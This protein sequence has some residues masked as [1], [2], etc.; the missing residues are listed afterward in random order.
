MSVNKTVENVYIRQS[1][2]HIA[3]QHFWRLLIINVIYIVFVSGLQELLSSIISA[4]M[5]PDILSAAQQ[6][7]ALSSQA[8]YEAVAGLLL[9]PK[10]LLLFFLS[11]LIEGLVISGLSLGMSHQFLAAAK[12]E[13]PSPLGLF[14]R[15]K[16]CISSLLLTILLTA[17]TILWMLPGLILLFVGISLY[18][19][20][21]EA[22]NLITMLGQGM[23]IGL[24]IPA[25]Y[26]YAMASWALA[27]NVSSTRECIRRSKDYMKDRKWQ[28]FRLSVPILLKAIGAGIGMLLLA[29]LLA[30]L[31]DWVGFIV[32]GAC[33]VLLG[34]FMNQHTL[35]HALFYVE[36]AQ[37]VKEK[38]VSFW[39]RDPQEIKPVSAWQPAPEAP[40]EE[41]ASSAPEAASDNSIDDAPDT[42]PEASDT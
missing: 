41:P 2:A 18:T 36:R 25:A 17:K 23:M 39:L 3:R 6:M 33:A 24:G 28:F 38:P 29:S 27:D 34:Y 32:L 4:M 11:M 7:N 1:A 14:C 10:Y 15:M 12:G 31:A 35:A 40:Q 42:T 8:R 30:L 5:Q 22:G 16:E 20:G 26:R 21:M 37:P 9:S 19:A 13:T